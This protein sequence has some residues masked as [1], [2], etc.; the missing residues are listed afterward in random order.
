LGQSEGARQKNKG[1][2]R[3]EALHGVT[4]VDTRKGRSSL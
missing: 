1:N 2:S 4:P 3:A